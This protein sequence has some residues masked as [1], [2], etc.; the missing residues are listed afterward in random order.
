MRF[1]GQS[2]DGLQTRDHSLAVASRLN[3]LRI[4]IAGA[5]I[6]GIL[7]SWRLWF[8]VG[9]TFPRVP[10]V[11]G[12]PAFILSHDYLL[13]IL[14]LV[15]LIVS[16]VS[17]Q[18]R[19]YLVA[20]VTLTALLVLFDLT[21]LQPWVYQYVVMLAVLACR[22]PRSADP[23]PDGAVL[24]A[25]QLVIATL[26]FWSG[27]QKLNWSF[28]HEVMPGLLDSAG[29]H[30]SASYPKYLPAASVCIALCEALIGVGLLVRWTR[31]AMVL[32]ALGMHLVVLF[33]LV[34]A[35]RNSVVWVWN[36]GL[37]LMVVLLFWR[38]DHSLA[39]RAVWCW[40]ESELVN[41]MVKV[42]L[43]VCGLAPALSFFGWWDMYLSAALY[44][45]NTPV[46]VVRIS[47]QVRARLP[48]AAQQQVFTTKR[49]ELML[50]FYEWSL[51]D[52]NVPP[53]PEVRVYRQMARQVCV[54]AESPREIELII[55]ERPALID[56][57][58]AVKRSDCTDL[59]SR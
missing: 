12:L 42:V 22:R 36:I 15:V 8:G 46:G 59:L 45:G 44:S 58:Y 7:L 35:A 50:P 27:A 9:R 38:N 23:A 2:H 14:L 24:A 33:L 48:V 51:A 16:V 54:Y 52:L 25:G 41:H 18:S 55:K 40:R 21:R 37:M 53:Y 5:Y 34:V 20:V 10:V 30:L 31:Q 1:R 13:S 56:G 39:Q 32:V 11:K 47:E 3:Y 29:I 17:K 4:A 6:C 26:Y 43:V 28:A 49:G 57:S 19:R